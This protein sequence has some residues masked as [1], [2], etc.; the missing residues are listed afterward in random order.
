VGRIGGNKRAERRLRE[1]GRPVAEMT[2]LPG[3]SRVQD[4][5]RRKETEFNLSLKESAA[6]NLNKRH[7]VKVFNDIHYLTRGWR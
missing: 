6:V 7:S 3:E 5:L 4:I 1:A 2:D